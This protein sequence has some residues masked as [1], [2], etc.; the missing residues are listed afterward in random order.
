MGVERERRGGEWK[1]EEE[2]EEEEEKT[3]GNPSHRSSDS[4][5]ASAALPNRV[6]EQLSSDGDEW[7]GGRS[8]TKQ[9]DRLVILTPDWCLA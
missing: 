6:V 8:I 7:K 5:S 4:A 2:A 3:K 9:K 1:G